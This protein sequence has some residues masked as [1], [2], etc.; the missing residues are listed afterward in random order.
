MTGVCNPVSPILVGMDTP[1]TPKPAR[2]RYSDAEQAEALT[3]LA[4]NDGRIRATARK[5]GIPYRTLAHWAA[6]D[7]RPV[8]PDLARQNKE[9]LASACERLARKM[10]VQARKRVADMNGRDAT[11]AGAVLVDKALLLR[12][13]ATSIHET[14]DDARLEEFRKRYASR[15][16][17]SALE[18]KQLAQVEPLPIPSPPA[19]TRP[20][21]AA[22][23]DTPDTTDPTT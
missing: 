4:A 17:S 10:F 6:G 19:D 16:L 8:V 9:Q 5:L 11:I 22:P 21:P 12:G 20:E 2:R 23:P 1:D 15:T 7:G 3:A 18:G 14:R 13:E